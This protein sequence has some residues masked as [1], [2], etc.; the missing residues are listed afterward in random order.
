VNELKKILASF[1][2]AVTAT[3]TMPGNETGFFFSFANASNYEITLL[4]N[5]KS[6]IVPGWGTFDSPEDSIRTITITN[7]SSGKYYLTVYA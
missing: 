4:I 1:S 6:T 7:P 2:G 3:H 5:G